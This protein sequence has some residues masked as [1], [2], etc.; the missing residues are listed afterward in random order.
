MSHT[1]QNSAR[2]SVAGPL[3]AA[4]TGSTPARTGP[5]L[6]IALGIV[7]LRGHVSESLR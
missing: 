3:A 4:R 5:P 2:T 6:T 1:L 7:S